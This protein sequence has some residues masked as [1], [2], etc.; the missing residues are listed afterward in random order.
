MIDRI[1]TSGMPSPFVGGTAPAAPPADAGVVTEAPSAPAYAPAGSRDQ[2]I[3][4]GQIGAV[5]GDLAVPSPGGEAQSEAE[6]VKASFRRLLG[7]EV[8]DSA[9]MAASM[10]LANGHPREDF[11]KGIMESEER[12]NLTSLGF[13]E[14]SPTPLAPLQTVPH[15]PIYDSIKLPLTNLPEMV[16]QALREAKTLRPDI[17]AKIE[18]QGDV[19]NV[20]KEKWFAYELMTTTIGILRANGIDASRVVAFG[21]QAVGDPG[22]YGFDQLRIGNGPAIDVMGG[23]EGVCFLEQE[24]WSRPENA[25]TDEHRKKE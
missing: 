8:D 19:K 18:K 12:K 2:S 10:A 9:M 15:L 13:T 23:D 3:V 25:P 21:E 24:A 20:K 7:R 11:L 22:R 17:M 4:S 14:L 1:G 5:Q 6:F 16:M